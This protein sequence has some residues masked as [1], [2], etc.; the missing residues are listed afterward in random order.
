MRQGATGE[1]E[2]IQL[3]S[4]KN[5]LLAMCKVQEKEMKSACRNQSG[6]HCSSRTDVRETKKDLVL[7]V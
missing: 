6:S 4:K 7:A 5:I 1:D 3:C 2:M